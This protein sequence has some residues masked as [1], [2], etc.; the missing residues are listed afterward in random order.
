M[1]LLLAHPHGPE[2][3][4]VSGKLIV[5]LTLINRENGPVMLGGQRLVLHLP[6]ELL[7]MM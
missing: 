3:D 7:V 4:L 2:E 1:L 5:A 6:L